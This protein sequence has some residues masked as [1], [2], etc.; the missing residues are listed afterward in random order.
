M[1]KKLSVLLV[2]A[3]VLFAQP[4]PAFAQPSQ[5]PNAPQAP[6]WYGPG[7]WHMW[8]D[9]YGWPFWWIGPVMMM[10]FMVLICGAFIYFMF[11]RHSPSGGPSHWGPSHMMDRQWN[12]SY[13]A[14]QILDERYAR[15]E[16]QKEEYEE[17]KA[18]ILSGRSR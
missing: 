13:S 6:Q 17:R 1:W 3:V 16:I 5:S 8:G 15:G 4:L 10:L 11:S 12:P 2:S 18:T 7:P 9:G 14:L